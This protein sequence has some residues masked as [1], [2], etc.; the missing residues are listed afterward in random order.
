MAGLLGGSGATAFS[1][2][3]S[4]VTVAGVLVLLGIYGSIVRR[5]A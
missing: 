2:W 3:S 5:I 1:V 4:L